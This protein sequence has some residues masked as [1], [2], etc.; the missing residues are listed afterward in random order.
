M[1]NASTKNIATIIYLPRHFMEACN[2][3]SPHHTLVKFRIAI[4]AWPS[5]KSS[6]DRNTSSDWVLLGWRLLQHTLFI[7]VVGKRIILTGN[8]R[9]IGY[10]D[11]VLPIACHLEFT[12]QRILAASPLRLAF[13]LVL[14]DVRHTLCDSC[15]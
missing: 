9:C 7:E 15:G 8:G 10:A 2:D 14:S 4:E 3:P 5:K 12:L 11:S 6:K 13:V 1:K